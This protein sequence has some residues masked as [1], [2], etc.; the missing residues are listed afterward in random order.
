VGVGEGEKRRE[1]GAAA[2]Y[3]RVRWGLCAGR[4]S[5]YWAKRADAVYTS[6]LLMS[7]LLVFYV[8]L[9][10]FAT[11]ILIYLELYSYIFLFLHITMVSPHL[12]PFHLKGKKGVC[13]LE[14]PYHLKNYA[15][16]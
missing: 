1:S 8:E 9:L 7:A 3:T 11:F 15:F 4:L 16:M 6:G 2:F 13:R 12:T 5:E 10:L 14:S